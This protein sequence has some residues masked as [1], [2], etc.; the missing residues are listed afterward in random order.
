MSGEETR[1]QGCRKN[2]GILGIPNNIPEVGSALSAIIP[3]LLL[4]LPPL[5]TIIMI[6]QHLRPLDFTLNGFFPFSNLHF[7]E[8]FQSSPQICYPPFTVVVNVNC[9]NNK[10]K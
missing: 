6:P 9:S 8:S 7:L 4:F 3:L 1:L 5:H 2:V 10:N